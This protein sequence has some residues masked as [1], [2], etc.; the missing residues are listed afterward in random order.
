M[1]HGD[2]TLITPQLI[3]REALMI[4][5]S[6][7]VFLKNVNT[8]YQDE[9]KNRKG[10]D[11][12]MVK[13]PAKYRVRDGRIAAP[14]TSV[15]EEVPITLEQF[16]TDLEFTSAEMTLSVEKFSKQFIQPAMAPIV[17][18]IDSRLARLVNDC[19]LYTSPSPRDS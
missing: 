19:L 6:N 12:I 13:K 17:G 16:G 3:A 14:Q 18:R 9:F 7:S 8:S 5:R 4:I 1:Q 2:N 11:T 10:G 15:Q